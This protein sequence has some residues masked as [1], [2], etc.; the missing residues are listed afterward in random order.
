MKN[1][2]V[3]EKSFTRSIR[4]SFKLISIS[5]SNRNQFERS[6]YVWLSFSKGHGQIGNFILA[7]LSLTNK[8]KRKIIN[9]W[10]HVFKRLLRTA[11]ACNYHG[12]LVLDKFLGQLIYGQDKVVITV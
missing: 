5:N 10:P 9:I 1:Q 6:L 4:R 2:T 11:I 12:E 7:N 3:W 8:D